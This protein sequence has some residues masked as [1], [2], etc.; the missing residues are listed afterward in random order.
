MEILPN[1]WLI[2]ITSG[3]RLESPMAL[4][5]KNITTMDLYNT[6]IS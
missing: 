4:L 5:L 2:L 3:K 6:L 1:N